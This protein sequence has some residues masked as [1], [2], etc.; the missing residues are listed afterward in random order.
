MNLSKPRVDVG[1]NTNN[2]EPMLQF[3][4]Q[5]VGAKFDHVLAVA[6]GTRQHR[7]ADNGRRQAVPAQIPRCPHGAPPVCAHIMSLN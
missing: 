7:H 3:W 1:L 4:Q 5:E 2:L 6:K